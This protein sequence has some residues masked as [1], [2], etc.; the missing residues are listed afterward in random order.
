[1]QGTPVKDLQ[2]SDEVPTKHL[3][4]FLCHTHPSLIWPVNMMH[5]QVLAFPSSLSSLHHSLISVAA[6]ASKI[7][8]WHKVLGEK[9]FTTFL[10]ISG[11]ERHRLGLF[12]VR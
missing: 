9:S 6:V 7:S 12:S 10:H 4:I 3:K 1:L 5:K 2:D 8:L 11:R